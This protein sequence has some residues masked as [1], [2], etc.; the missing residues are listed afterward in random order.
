MTHPNV[1][2]LTL[3]LLLAGSMSQHA[4][5]GTPPLGQ[6]PEERKLQMTLPHSQSPVWLK[7]V[8]CKVG[9]NDKNDLYHIAVT[10]EVKAL[11]GQPVMVNG[12]VMPLDASDHTQHFLLTR[13]TPVCM[14]CPPGEPN[15][16]VEVVAP[17]RIVWTNKIVTVTGPLTLVN[18]GEKGIFFKI[19]AEKVQ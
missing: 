11:A 14:F 16:V 13:N 18:N 6:P 2:T 12:F 10:P 5:A 3:S 9:Y 7:F 1:T 4:A 8:K 17:R 19:I 15:E